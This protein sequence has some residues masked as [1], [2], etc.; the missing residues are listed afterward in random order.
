MSVKIRIYWK[1][2]IVESHSSFR[3]R[4]HAVS[5]ERC[6]VPSTL[7]RLHHLHLQLLSLLPSRLIPVRRRLVD[8]AGQWRK[9]APLP[10][11]SLAPPTL[12]SPSIALD[13]KTSTPGWPC[14]L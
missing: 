14:W 11:P 4:E 12:Q 8:H 2:F 10:S 1:F 6:S 3:N 9:D 5:M 13:S 7:S